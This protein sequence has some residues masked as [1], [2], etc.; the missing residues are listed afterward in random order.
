M[1]NHAMR[2][3]RIRSVSDGRPYQLTD[4]PRSAFALLINSFKASHGA[5]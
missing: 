5:P 1:T 3:S 2:I 4:R